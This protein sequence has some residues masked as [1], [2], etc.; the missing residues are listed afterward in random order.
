MNNAPSVADQFFYEELSKIVGPE[1]SKI[2]WSSISRGVG[3]IQTSSRT[4]TTSTPCRSPRSCASPTPQG[5]V[6]PNPRIFHQ[7]VLYHGSDSSCRWV[8]PTFSNSGPLKTVGFS[9]SDKLLVGTHCESG[10]DQCN[11]NEVDIGKNERLG[12]L[13][14]D[15]A[16]SV[17]QDLSRPDLH[18]KRRRSTVN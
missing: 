7:N 17:I 15:A 6:S 9:R 11:P 16:H 12:L 8:K 4:S 10:S 1:T 14:T 3:K 5:S 18:M 13:F 2:W